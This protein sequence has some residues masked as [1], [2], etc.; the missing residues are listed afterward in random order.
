MAACWLGWL[1]EIVLEDWLGE[2]PTLD[3]LKRL[4][5]SNAPMLKW[6]R[7]G[8]LGWLVVLAGWAGWLLTV[9]CLLL[10][11]GLAGWPACSLDIDLVWPVGF[12][13]L[14]ELIGLAGLLGLRLEG[15]SLSLRAW[16][17]G[18]KLDWIGGLG[19]LD[20][21]WNIL[22]RNFK[23]STPREVG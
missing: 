5:D 23:R 4:L 22:C 14:T 17:F 8:G 10:L 19:G 13:G 7:L 21:D 16:R 3:A 12:A 11:F 18:L 1:D 9:G 6:S 20:M 15:C 2:S